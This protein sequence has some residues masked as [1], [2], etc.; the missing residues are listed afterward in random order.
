[1]NPRAMKRIVGR[2]WRGE[3]LNQGVT[4]VFTVILNVEISREGQNNHIRVL[5]FT[6]GVPLKQGEI[7]Q[8]ADFTGLCPRQRLYPGLCPPS[9]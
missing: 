8:F 2:M 7:R 9:R 1:M 5:N 4:W 6:S 3:A